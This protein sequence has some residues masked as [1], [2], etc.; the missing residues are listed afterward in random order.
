MNT[1]AKGL[2]PTYQPLTETGSKIL[3][4]AI[5]GEEGKAPMSEEQRKYLNNMFL[6]Q[7]LKKRLEVFKLP[8]EFS[9]DTILAMLAFV[10]RPGTMMVLLIDCLNAY[11]GKKVTVAML[12]DLYPTGFYDEATFGRYIDDFLKTRKVKWSEV[13]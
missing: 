4:S 6:V 3:L 10:D 11:E 2:N 7:V 12:V 8:I 13:Y 5:I 9:D 1:W